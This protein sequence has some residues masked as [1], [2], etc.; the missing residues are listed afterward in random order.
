M[1]IVI[2]LWVCGLKKGIALVIIMTTTYFT[3]AN[4]LYSAT[5]DPQW[6]DQSS[7]DKLVNFIPV[8]SRYWSTSALFRRGGSLWVQILG[9]RGRC[10]QPFWYQK[11]SVFLLPHSEDCMILSLFV[12]VQYQHVID[13]LTDGIA[14][15][16]TLLI[17]IFNML[18]A[19]GTFSF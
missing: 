17:I 13:R 7:Y 5:T 10:P 8:I 14:M 16:N 4:H 1:E 18:L 9:G 2:T 6:T 19:G 15:A 3:D 12:W 11:T